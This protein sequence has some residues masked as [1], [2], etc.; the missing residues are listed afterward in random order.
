MTDKLKD[1]RD[2][3]AVV[4]ENE[5]ANIIV[6]FTNNYTPILKTNLFTITV[7]LF[8]RQTELIINGVED[9]S[10]FDEHNGSVDTDGTLTWRLSPEDNVIIDTDLPTGSLEE[11]IARFTWTWYDG[12]QARTG[13]KE[14]S[15]DV[16]RLAVPV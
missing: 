16:R 13:K 15:F 5:S 3:V 11:H 2:N 4:D 14:V 10:V 1:S 7:T 9:T 6:K 8:D 12:I